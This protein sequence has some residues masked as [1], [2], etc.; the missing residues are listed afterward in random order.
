MVPGLAFNLWIA[1]S[2]ATRRWLATLPC[3]PCHCCTSGHVFRQLLLRFTELTAAKDRHSL[4]SSGRVTSAFQP[5]GNQPAGMEPS[6]EWHLDL[7]GFATQ[8]NH[9]E[10]NKGLVYPTK[11][12]NGLPLL[13]LLASQISHGPKHSRLFP[14]LFLT[15]QNV[16]VRPHC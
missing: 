12:G 1:P 5:C 16:A 8:E 7:F 6:A 15:F 13:E 14:S 4:L 3:R 10:A 9:A 2:N 11:I